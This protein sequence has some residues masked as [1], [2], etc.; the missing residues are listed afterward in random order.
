MEEKYGLNDVRMIE[1]KFI[2]E[3]GRAHA[4]RIKKIFNIGEG[5]S[6]C[7]KASAYAPENFIEDFRIETQDEKH[8]I[9][10][11]PS[12]TAQKARVKRCLNE[13]PCKEAGIL[14][15]S[16]FFNEIDENITFSCIVAPPDDH[17][18]DC[19]CKWRIDVS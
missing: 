17:P 2:G 14:Y 12:C 16:N 6:E 5:I 3:V 13:Y 15:F 11:N 19:Y 9:F 18:D 8:A 4:K 10:Y 1:L 7:I